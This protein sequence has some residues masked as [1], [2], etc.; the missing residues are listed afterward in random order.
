MPV[1][2]SYLK[3]KLSVCIG[4]HTKVTFIP[5]AYWARSSAGDDDTHSIR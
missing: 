2:K 1:I 4:L 3:G 5:D